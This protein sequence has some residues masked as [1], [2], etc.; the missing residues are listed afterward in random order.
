M[1]IPAGRRDIR[2]FKAKERVLTMIATA[3]LLFVA[4]ACRTSSGGT[5]TA[6]GQR[7]SLDE[8]LQCSS[9]ALGGGAVSALSTIEL[10]LQSTPA[11]ELVGMAAE[12]R[13]ITIELPSS[14]TR[15]T[16]T[17]RPG[18]AVADAVNAWGFSGS[19]S[20]ARRSTPA[21]AIESMEVEAETTRRL[22]QEFARLMLLWL[23]RT[24]ET[25]PVRLSLRGFEGIPGHRSAV[26]AAVGADSFNALLRIDEAS[27]LPV[28]I[29]T[30]R[31]STMSDAMR[32]RILKQT[33][34]KQTRTETVFVSGHVR[35]HGVMLPTRMHVEVEGATTV[36]LVRIS[37]RVN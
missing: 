23:A 2:H 25:V 24:T 20:F 19:R 28:S 14:F 22:K 29:S 18:S 33:V 5:G 3:V 1:D 4:P 11:P 30:E 7:T 32:E 10:V 36:N 37:A 27:C 17:R 21:G 6:D 12:T 13:V 31:P 34:T 15:E 8:I 26:I 35:V 16:R 9:D